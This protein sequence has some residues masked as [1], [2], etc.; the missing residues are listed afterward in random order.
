MSSKRLSIFAVDGKQCLK[1]YFRNVVGMVLSLH[2][3]DGI[4][5]M[6]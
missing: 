1:T 5:N 4:P 3:L 2:D 6:V